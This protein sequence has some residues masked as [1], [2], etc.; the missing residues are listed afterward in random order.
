MID[1]KDYLAQTNSLRTSLTDTASIITGTVEGLYYR[2]Y[3]QSE[4]PVEVVVIYHGGGVS[5]DAGYDILARQ[6]CEYGSVAVCLVDIRGHGY[7][8]GERGTVE[9]PACVWRDV[10]RLLAE[11][12]RLFP[13]ARRHLLGHSS[14]AGMLLN[15]F[16]LYPFT[17]RADSLV[18][19]APELGP[20]SGTAKK[21]TWPFARVRQWPFVVNALSGGRLVG[22]RRAVSLHFPDALAEPPAGLVRHYSVNMANALTPRHPGRQLAALPIATLIL[23]AAQD[24]I[25]SPHA[26]GELVSRAENARLAFQ[27]IEQASHLACIFVAHPFIHH[28]LMNIKPAAKGLARD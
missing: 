2:L 23:A 25:I 19:L 26:L 15:Y 7:S 9:R 5:G 27:S 6:L 17:E 3:R 10:D 21:T 12:R 1:F 14:G 4:E 16:T 13:N 28:F 8:T 11:M 18:L 22:Q 20:F 24:E